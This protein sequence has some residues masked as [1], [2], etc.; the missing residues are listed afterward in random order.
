MFACE[1]VKERTPFVP[2]NTATRLG[3]GRPQ[4]RDKQGGTEQQSLH[5]AL[6]EKTTPISV[7]GLEVSMALKTGFVAVFVTTPC[8]FVAE[9]LAVGCIEI[10]VTTY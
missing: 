8:N 3:R 9:D 6:C 4:T 1:G 2:T 7:F 10:S 5:S